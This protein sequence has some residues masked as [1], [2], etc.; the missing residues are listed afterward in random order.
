[1]AIIEVNEVVKSFMIPSVRRATV[2]AHALDLFRPRPARKLSVLDGVSFEVKPGETV[3]VMGRN[4]SG[5]STLLRIVAGIYRPDR[6]TVVARAPMTPILELGLGWNSELDAVDN[7]LL[8]G[9]VLGRSLRELRAAVDEIL[10]FAE[11]EA[12]ANVKL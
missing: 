10:A 6:G 12:F 7:I 1:M 4:G 11:L 2:R 5:K 9:S 3:G 8:L